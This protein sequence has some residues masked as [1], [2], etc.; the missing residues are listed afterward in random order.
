MAHIRLNI[1]LLF[2]FCLAT[3]NLQAQQAE[4]AD[5]TLMQEV[6]INGQRQRISYRLDRQRIDASQVLTAQGGTAFDVLRAVPG[7][8]VDADGS[9]S[10]RG[11]QEFLVYVDGKPSPLS[12][13][14]ALQ[15]IGAASIKDIEIL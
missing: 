14:E 15:M 5:S 8:V 7:V 9:L 6:S 12:G 10:Y 1:T 2:L 3:I 13:T 11:S 4:R